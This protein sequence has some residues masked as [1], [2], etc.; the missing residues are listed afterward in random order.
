MSLEDAIQKVETWVGPFPDG[1]PKAA[2]DFA[3]R[4]AIRRVIK[5]AK[6]GREELNRIR[7]ET[8]KSLGK[9]EAE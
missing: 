7:M 2:P 3:M 9:V 5:G 6:E 1:E 4:C 8:G